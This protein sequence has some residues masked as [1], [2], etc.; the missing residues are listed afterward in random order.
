M[1]EEEQRRSKKRLKE[2]FKSQRAQEQLIRETADIPK[3]EAQIQKDELTRI[4]EQRRR[5]I[6]A[7]NNMCRFLEQRKWDLYIQGHS[8]NAVGSV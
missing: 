7:L 6:Y 4:K 3:K 5:E 2:Y 8:D 1:A